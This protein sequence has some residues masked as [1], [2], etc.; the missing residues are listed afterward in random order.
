M[1]ARAQIRVR[2]DPRRRY[3]AVALP[4]VEPSVH[5]KVFSARYRSHD[6]RETELTQA[7]YHRPSGDRGRRSRRGEFRSSQS[8]CAGLPVDGR[9]AAAVVAFP[10]LADAAAA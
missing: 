8:D 5:G 4:V 10:D 7:A 2:T 6:L 1:A 9:V 3:G